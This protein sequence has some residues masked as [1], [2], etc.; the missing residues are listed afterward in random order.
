MNH[1]VDGA[2]S[3]TTNLP[4]VFQVF[5]CEVAVM[6]WRDL[7]L[8]RRL[9]A[10]CTQALSGEQEDIKGLNQEVKTQDKLT[11]EPRKVKKDRSNY[12]TIR[13]TWIFDATKKK[14]I[15]VINSVAS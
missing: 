9:D 15:S 4:E 1:L 6:L 13:G 11:G 2:I 8:S 3:P 14:Y 5:C 12:K 7:Q 10:V